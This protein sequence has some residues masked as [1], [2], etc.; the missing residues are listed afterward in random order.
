MY[1]FTT[2][3]MDTSNQAISREMAEEAIKYYVQFH[4]KP[5][6]LEAVPELQQYLNHRYANTNSDREAQAAP[7]TK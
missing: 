3:K 5:G 1:T 2:F 4:L 7:T 6:D